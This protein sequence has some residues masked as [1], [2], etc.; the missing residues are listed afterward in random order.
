MPTTNG[1]HRMSR[2]AT[3]A[4]AIAPPPEIR[5]TRMTRPIVD[6]PSVGTSV[7][8]PRE[9]NRAK[10]PSP[11]SSRPAGVVACQNRRCSCRLPKEGPS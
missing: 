10:T 9:A 11:N 6:R 5:E 1:I 4:Y 3:T 8:K 2:K 7:R